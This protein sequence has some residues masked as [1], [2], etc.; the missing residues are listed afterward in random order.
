MK[1]TNF[2]HC[3]DELTIMYT[4]FIEVY[5]LTIS[6]PATLLTNWLFAAFCLLFGHKL[7][8]NHTDKYQKN[9]SFYFLFIGLASITGGTAHGFFNYFG[10]N[11]HLVAWSFIGIGVYG[12]EL[13]SS[14][15]IKDTRLRKILRVISM[16]KLL[17]FFAALA[18]YQSFEVVRINTALGLL[19]IVLIVHLGDYLKNK[20]T[21]S[22]IVV[23]AVFAMLA[24]AAVHA[25]RISYNQWFNHNDLSHIVM[26][27]SFYVF[28]VGAD[29]A[30]SLSSAS[31]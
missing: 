23:L 9:W 5:G 16:I 8:H 30:G 17:L 1:Y 15:I 10:Q 26:I 27:L 22:S 12:S 24:P 18:Y 25:F 29:R 13:A 7:Y 3:V 19:G 4:P 28:Y 21:S 6:E 31:A 20:T 14:Y 2:A 11:L